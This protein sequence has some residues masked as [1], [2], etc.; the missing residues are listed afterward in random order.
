LKT[1]LL[2]LAATALAATAALATALPVADAKRPATT[3]VTVMTR[4][5]FLGADLLPL[6]VARPG[7]EFEAAAGKVLTQVR[8]SQSAARMKLVAGEIAKAKPDLVGLQEV[9]LWRTGPKGDPARATHVE[10]DYLADL[11]KEL[12]RRKAPYRV[13]A[14]QR[15][16]DL[17]GPSDKGVDVRFTDGNVILARK[18][19][20]VTKSRSSNFNHQLVIPTKAI[21]NVSVN[22]SFNQ[23]DATVRGA[24]FHFV[25]AHLEA[26]SAATRL[27]QAKELVERA[28][29]SK[30]QTVLV[31][32]LNSGPNLP[33]S[34]DRPPYRAIAG[35][36][37]KEARTAKPQCCF[38]DDLKSGK[39]DHIVDHI[40]ARPKVKLVRSFVTGLEKTAGGLH[41]SDHGGVVSVLRIER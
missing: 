2:P 8:S 28:L 21:G 40:M 7:Q 18:G 13:V 9:T 37:F 29:A 23:L 33:K 3:D 22:R 15:T 27:D 30:R 26:Y 17:E 14:D 38:N 31:G 10:I 4:N 6:A 25:N 5:L 12:A 20:K 32:D 34:E 35:A 16:L 41:P 39:W 36:G 11:R 1:P 19:V 24:R